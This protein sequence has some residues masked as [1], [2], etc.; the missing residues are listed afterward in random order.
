MLLR[1]FFN[2]RNCSIEL[3]SDSA[4][5]KVKNKANTEIQP[6]ALSL[7]H[8]HTSSSFTVCS[9][10]IGSSPSDVFTVSTEEALD[11]LKMPWTFTRTFTLT[12]AHSPDSWG[13]TFW[14]KNW[15]VK[16]DVDI[17][18]TRIEKKTMQTKESNMLISAIKRIKKLKT[19]NN[20]LNLRYLYTCEGMAAPSGCCSKLQVWRA[21]SGRRSKL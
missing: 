19:K 14:I 15:P 10:S 2:G 6:T 9:V 5:Q 18:K 17:N 11:T 4:P 12:F 7:P 13:T 3:W 8:T 21:L 20:L 16:S 1:E